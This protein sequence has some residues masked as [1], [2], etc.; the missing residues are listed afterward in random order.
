MPH[1]DDDDPPGWFIIALFIIIV[2]CLF[3]MYKGFNSWREASNKARCEGLHNNFDCR[4]RQQIKADA[5]L[6]IKRQEK[7][8]RDNE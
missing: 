5:R 7:I 1:W 6:E 4:V 8:I 2:F 3:G